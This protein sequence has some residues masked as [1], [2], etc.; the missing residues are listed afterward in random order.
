MYRE[1]LVT[2][3]LSELAELALP[4][5]R[6]LARAFGSSIILLSVVQ[7]MTVQP[8]PG[9]VGP[10]ISICLDIEEESERVKSYLGDIADQMRKEDLQVQ[11]EVREGDPASEICDYAESH[12]IDIIVMT[13][14]S[15]SGIQRWVY[16]SVADKVLRHASVPVLLVRAP[17]I[18][19]ADVVS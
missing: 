10:V 11:V 8:E 6:E 16:G 4:H 18:L 13:T 15:R 12:P 19:R 17:M 7:A 5:A 9:T 1:I 14:H 2:L 3:D